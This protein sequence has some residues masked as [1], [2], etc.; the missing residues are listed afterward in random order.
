MSYFLVCVATLSFVLIGIPNNPS[1]LI[2][3]VPLVVPFIVIS[4]QFYYSVHDASAL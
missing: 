2:Y 1:N 3:A 4:I